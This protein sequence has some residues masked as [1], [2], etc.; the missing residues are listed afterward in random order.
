MNFDEDYL[1]DYDLSIILYSGEADYFNYLNDINRLIKYLKNEKYELILIECE[2]KNRFTTIEK[3]I[4]DPKKLL[5]LKNKR[6]LGKY[7]L[8]SAH[9]MF[10]K[11]N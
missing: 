3:L 4:N 2:L 6:F 10:K 8:T 9:L 5:K 7:K 11:I 1:F